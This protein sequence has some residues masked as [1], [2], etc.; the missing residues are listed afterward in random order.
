M[1][2]TLLTDCDGVLLNWLSGIPDFLADLGMDSGHLK[3]RLEGNQF[4]PIEEIFMSENME[5]ALA[6]MSEYQKSEYL[7]K[8]PV[9][10]PGCELPISRLSEEYDIVVVTSFSEDKSAHK[11]RE[12]NLKLH[13]GDAISDLICLPFSANKTEA[14]RELATSTN[15]KIW[16]D[17]QIKH[18][19]HGIN[20]GIEESY[21]YTWNMSCG[22]NT[23]EVRELDSWHKVEEKLL[24]A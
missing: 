16:I 6:R 24:S 23:G 22:R 19:H 1:K 21:Q 4:V 20:A 15:A 7:K 17:D 9:M 5:D 8:L 14:L 2:K 3:A 11:N 13:Y 18:V 10:E 12:D